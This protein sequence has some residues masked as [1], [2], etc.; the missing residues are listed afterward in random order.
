MVEDE[1]SHFSE[2]FAG[3]GKSSTSHGPVQEVVLPL[4]AE[5]LDQLSR[6]ANENGV[7]GSN[8]YKRS[9]A[10]QIAIDKF[11]AHSAETGANLVNEL[12]FCGGTV[13]PRPLCVFKDTLDALSRLEQELHCSET[14]LLETAIRHASGDLVQEPVGA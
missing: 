6:I 13:K 4:H 5:A 8:E 7:E 3:D 1:A 14:I 2:H 10:L 9:V 12:H 11:R